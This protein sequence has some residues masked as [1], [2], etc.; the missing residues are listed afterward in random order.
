MTTNPD[1]TMMSPPIENLLERTKSKFSLVTLAAKRAREITEYSG[2]LRMSEVVGPT[3]ET[4]ST[5]HLSVAFEEI[6]ADKVRFVPKT[7]EEIRAEIAEL[8]RQEDEA[9]ALAASEEATTQP[10]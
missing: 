5:K 1:S 4:V 8:Q 6:A 3:V 10:E 9:N 7:L 2:N